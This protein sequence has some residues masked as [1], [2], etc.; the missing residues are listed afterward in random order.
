MKGYGF[1]A[2]EKAFNEQMTTTTKSILTGPINDE[3]Q[4]IAEAYNRITTDGFGLGVAEIQN[5]LNSITDP[6]ELENTLAMVEAAI[7]SIRG[8]AA[9]SGTQIAGLD[10]SGG[11]GALREFTAFQD[12][13]NDIF[14]D[15]TGAVNQGSADQFLNN[16]FDRLITADPSSRVEVGA[17]MIQEILAGLTNIPSSERNKVINAIQELITPQDTDNLI[18]GA[19]QV[20][21]DLD[22]LKELMGKGTEVTREELEWISDR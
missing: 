15:P 20:G 7:P 18:F 8:L 17:R 1:N 4:S 6:E 16:I 22:K 10:A 11:M 12:L 19:F 9:L 14:K 21:G 5:I 2:F 13:A 3:A